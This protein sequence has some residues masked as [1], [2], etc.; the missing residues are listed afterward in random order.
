MIV[1]RKFSAA[2]Q[3]RGYQ[4][5]CEN[6]HGHTYGVEVHFS[7]NELNELGLAADFKELKSIIDA[8]LENYDH[9][10][11]NQVPPFDREN[12]SAENLAR[13]IFQALETEMPSGI[14]LARVV[15]WESEDAGAAFVNGQ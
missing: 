5:K 14:S 8:H 13:A 2:H 12:P 10:L 6:L 15:V 11:L 1:K 7:A 9:A 4:G 3:L